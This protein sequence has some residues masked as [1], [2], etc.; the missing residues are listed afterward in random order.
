MTTRTP[1]PA[2]RLGLDYA[3]EATRFDSFG[4]RIIDVHTHINGARASEIYARAA[5]QYGIGKTYSMS[6]YEEIDNVRAALGDTVRFIAV[7]DFWDKDN[8]RHAFG[9]G[10]LERI[11]QWH[12]E[13]SRIVKFWV[14]PRS[15]D[16]G[17]EAGD[18]GLMLLD[19]PERI[20]A[21]E[22]ATSL[23]MMFMVHVADPNTWFSTKYTDASFYGTKASQYEPLE[24]V[25][26][27]FTQ[28]WIAAHMGGW[29]EDL[30]FLT[31]LLE[32][33]DNLHLDSSAT[34]WMVREL[35]AQPRE[36]LLAFLQ[37]FRGRIL[38]GSDIVTTDEHLDADDENEMQ[39][40]ASSEEEAYD[41][42]ASR[43]WALRTMFDTDYE[44]ES[45]IADP[46]L[47]MVDPARDPMDAPPLVGKSLPTDVLRDLYFEAAEALLGVHA[48]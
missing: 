36:E 1:T 27:R 34:K 9:A 30:D 5:R 44:G 48:P 26:D 32:R 14:A 6:R 24:V 11:R 12:A 10:F 39:A 47:A 31:G 20:E 15:R 23:G 4:G 40:K 25:L 37:R 16:Y 18:P 46:D 13:G 38:F 43:Y 8:R 35:S 42:Y 45:P 29:P 28:P 33:H 2:N 3:A 7:P 19:R 41:L 21:M 17:K 22:L